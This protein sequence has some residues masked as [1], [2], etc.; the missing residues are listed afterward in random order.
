[1]PALTMV[2][3]LIKSSELVYTLLVVNNHLESNKLTEKDKEVYRE[4]MKDPDKQ[5]VSQGSRLLIGKLAEASAIRAV[6]G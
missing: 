5:K 1:M 3:L 2:P 4:M 6:Q